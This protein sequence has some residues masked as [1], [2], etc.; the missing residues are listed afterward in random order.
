MTVRSAS[1]VHFLPFSKS[2]IQNWKVR[3][4]SPHRGQVGDKLVHSKKGGDG[5]VDTP[6][7][8]DKIVNAVRS[9]IE[10]AESK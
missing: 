3:H 5:Y 8:A 1:I 4:R 9:A 10:A 7:K 2:K 6:E